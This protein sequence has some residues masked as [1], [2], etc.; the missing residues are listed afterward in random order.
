MPTSGTNPGRCRLR[1]VASNTLAPI[2]GKRRVGRGRTTFVP[3]RSRSTALSLLGSKV[4]TR[5]FGPRGSRCKTCQF[6]PNTNCPI[7][8]MYW[9]FLARHASLLNNNVR[10]RLPLRALGR[11]TPNQR[12]HDA[13]VFAAVQGMLQVGKP[14][15]Y[16]GTRIP[17]R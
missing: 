3:D 16:D 11:R 2:E 15:D 7:T 5:L 8:S 6:N 12:M 10:M 4:R 9:A 13:Q 14:I 17:L 1:L